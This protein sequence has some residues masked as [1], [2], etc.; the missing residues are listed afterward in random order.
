MGRLY[1]NYKGEHIKHTQADLHLNLEMCVVCGPV[2]DLAST[3]QFECV[4]VH[5]SNK[6]ISSLL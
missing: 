4:H 2:R 3:M 1:P 5:T 6:L